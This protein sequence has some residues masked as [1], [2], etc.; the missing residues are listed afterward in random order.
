MPPPSTKRANRLRARP[1]STLAERSA[2][3][4]SVA[5]RSIAAALLIACVMCFAGVFQHELW[6]PDEPREAEIGREM[7]I[8]GLSPMP[9]L[10]GQPFLEK[11]PLHP[12]MMAIAYR[13]FGVSPGV[14]RLPAALCSI[15]SILVAYWLG[16]RAAGRVAGIAS[17]IVLATTV[18]FVEVSH[19]AVNDAMLVVFVASGHLAFLAARDRER[20]GSGDRERW[21]SKGFELAIAGVCAG[22]A[23]LTK[24]F[25]GP[26][27]VA[28]PPLFAAAIMRE[29]RFLRF[30]LPRAAFWCTLFVVVLGAPWVFALER[31]GGWSAVRVCLVDNTI[32][33]SL[34][35]APEFGHANG[36]AYYL[37][38]FPLEALPWII[39]LPAAIV[40]GSLARTRRAG[41][42]QYLAWLVV[43]GLVI[44]SLPSTKRGLYALPLY[45]AASV[46]AGAWLA[47][48]GGTLAR[49]SSELPSASLLRS[50]RID[51]ATLIGL[52]VVFGSL[53][54]AVSA[55][56]AWI[57]WGGA[58]PAKLAS[59]TSFLREHYGIASANATSSTHSSLAAPIV[60]LIAG[61]AALGVLVFA[62]TSM[63]RSVPPLARSSALA[64]L[65]TILVWLCAMQPFLD[66][67]KDMSDGARR[68]MSVVPDDEPLLGLALDETTRAIIPYYTGR[69]VR[70]V[71]TTAEA[72]DALERGPSKHLV[73]MDNGEQNIDAALRVRLQP[74]AREK[75]DAART[76]NV[77]RYEERR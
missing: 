3:A 51:R 1:E 59:S 65:A 53:L 32:G 17:A 50:Q 66:P 33:R 25:I 14:A 34:Q 7:L 72:L 52:L 43:A 4:R 11:P 39:A 62:A 71:A 68:S 67:L 9:M 36:P 60:T 26:V 45:P 74:I 21:S 49:A 46:V 54:L 16:R 18:K 42:T 75:L 63:R 27:L 30:A 20:C 73:V 37:S 64:A 70:N 15:G 57:E 29:W 38:V 77:Y 55:T 61:L 23:F 44:L 13:A 31:A 19:C 41:R 58:A 8:S 22:L 47:R 40:S 69:L 28:A 48:A 10:D 24:S 56:A 76:L 6:T 35:A 2:P 5:R 12:W